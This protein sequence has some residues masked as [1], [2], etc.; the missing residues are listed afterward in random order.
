MITQY[1]ND[2]SEVDAWGAFGFYRR[3]LIS[4]KKVVNET[5]RIPLVDVTKNNSKKKF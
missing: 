1:G 3:K 5:L 2:Y 4:F